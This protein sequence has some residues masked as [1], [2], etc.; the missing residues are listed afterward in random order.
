MTRIL[1]NFIY[2]YIYIVNVFILYCLKTVSNV[3]KI[4]CSDDET[5]YWCWLVSTNAQL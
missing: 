3:K 5:L 1:H 4:N 2:I